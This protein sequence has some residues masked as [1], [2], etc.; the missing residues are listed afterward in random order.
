MPRLDPVAVAVAAGIAAACGPVPEDRAPRGEPDPVVER[1]DEPAQCLDR[2]ARAHGFGIGN[3]HARQR[4]EA[5]CV[6]AQGVECDFRGVI[7]REAAICILQATYP[8]QEEWRVDLA[9]HRGLPGPIWYAHTRLRWGRSHSKPAAVHA[10]TGEVLEALEPP[11][12]R[13]PLVPAARPEPE[14]KATAD[15]SYD[16]P[17][18]HEGG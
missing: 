8:K 15:E 7:S 11:D 3:R 1:L 10:A 12:P 6:R 4:A 9:F 2:Y 14:V 18:A 5:L 13:Q 16:A 17:Q